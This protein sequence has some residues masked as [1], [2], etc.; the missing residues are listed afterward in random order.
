MGAFKRPVHQGHCS[1]PQ[2]VVGQASDRRVDR[3]AVWGVRLGIHG[4]SPRGGVT[5]VYPAK[6]GKVR[7]KRP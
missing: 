2:L 3:N 7:E 4:V 1:T 6:P 5:I